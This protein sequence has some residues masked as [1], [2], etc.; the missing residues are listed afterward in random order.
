MKKVLSCVFPLGVLLMFG[1]WAEGAYG[2]PCGARELISAFG[3]LA[4]LTA[5]AAVLAELLLVS[6]AAW[7]EP[8]FGFDRLTRAH[9][10]LGLAVPAALLLHPALLLAGGAWPPGSPFTLRLRQMLSADD[11][12]AAAIGAFLILLTAVLSLPA[13]RRRMRYEVWHRSH[14]LAYAGLGLAIGHQFELGSDVGG[15]AAFAALWYALY[16]FAIGSLLWG[17]V[18]RPLLIFRRHRFVVEK[19]LPETTAAESIWITGRDIASFGAEAGQ[20]A[21]LRFWAPG[22]R[23]QAHPFS[24]SMRPDGDRLRFTVKK[25]G[26]FTS[27][28]HNSLRPGVPVLI[29]GPYGAVTAGKCLGDKALLIAG[30]IGITPLRALAESFQAS[31]KDSV[32]LYANR[33]Q[34]DV[35]FERELREMEKAGGLRVVHVLSE[36][37]GWSGEKGLLDAAMV[38]RLVPDLAERDV[39]LCG[40]GPMMSSLRR[41]LAELGISPGRIH[42]EEFSL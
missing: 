37:P 29:E 42:A 1:L 27:A 39:F 9:H 7:L 24:F 34:K 28:V 38:L 26:D 6:R 12:P 22:F 35:V 14:L 11:V 16:A 18:L 30:G 2:G 8:I 21:L 10:V 5:A 41:G 36:D 3:R 31:G 4:G 17:R 25:V 19:V 23:S 32:L 15:S 20:F 40:P 33:G 13:V